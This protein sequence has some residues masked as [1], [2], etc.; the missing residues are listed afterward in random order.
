MRLIYFY[1]FLLINSIKKSNAFF[2]LTHK[3]LG[4][5][6]E[7]YL[8]EKNVNMYN[9]IKSDINISSFG[10]ASIWADQIKFNNNYKWSRDLHYIDINECKTKIDINDVNKYCKNNCLIN[11][12]LNMTNDL[13]DSYIN[14]N[15]NSENA[16]KFKF[17]IHFLQ[18]F[19]QPL[20]TLG[21]YRGGNDDRI[22]LIKNGRR[23]NT[24]MHKLWDADLPEYFIKN[25]KNITDILINFNNNNNILNN[26]YDFEDFLIYQLNK[27]YNIG[28]K[29]T[30]LHNKTVIF[31]EY[32]DK[33]ILQNMF[34]TYMETVSSTFNYIY[35]K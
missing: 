7:K 17:L 8:I 4:N 10:N 11:G 31:D 32:Y 26:I 14:K 18:D 5:I 30:Y 35:N 1:S 19:T 34:I 23:V 3:F 29:K 20:H 21:F 24:N 16:E 13:R 12:I 27:I 25:N 33:D 2:S 22:I 28:C 9:L 6:Y 15:I